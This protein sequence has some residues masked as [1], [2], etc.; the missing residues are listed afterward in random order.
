MESEG[1]CVVVNYNNNPKGKSLLRTYVSKTLYDII[2]H[3]QKASIRDAVTLSDH[4]LHCRLI[5][6][7]SEAR[8]GQ[9]CFQLPLRNPSSLMC[10]YVGRADTYLYGY[11]SIQIISHRQLSYVCMRMKNIDYIYSSKHKVF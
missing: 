5:W 10:A 7:I 2:N 11:C 9:T 8:E 1:T 6:S 3:C 4:G